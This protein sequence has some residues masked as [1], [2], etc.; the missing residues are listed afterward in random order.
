MNRV[1]LPA[2]VK[3]TDSCPV[4]AF[5]SRPSSSFKNS[6]Q[7]RSRSS[8][9]TRNPRSMKKLSVVCHAGPKSSIVPRPNPSR[10]QRN[11][12][13]PFETRVN[14]C[15]SGGLVEPTAGIDP[16]GDVMRPPTG[17]PVEGRETF[18]VAPPPIP[19]PSL[20]N[21]PIVRSPSPPQHCRLLQS[22][23][24]QHCLKLQN[25]YPAAFLLPLCRATRLR[26][27]S[28][29]DLSALPLPPDRCSKV[30]RGRALST[31]PARCPAQ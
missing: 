21:S 26:L 9:V 11:S 18:L 30:V 16:F 29:D 17:I 4:M 6:F 22:H 7:E 12:F 31:F 27:Q 2:G 24:R 3:S 19:I 20:F 15:I 13:N 28:P 23:S 1:A 10:F 5:F 14:S 25:P 8:E